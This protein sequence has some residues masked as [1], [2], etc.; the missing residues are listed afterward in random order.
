MQYRVQNPAILSPDAHDIAVAVDREFSKKK[1]S[2]ST[3]T[4]KTRTSTL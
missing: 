4:D 3:T 1:L 2:V